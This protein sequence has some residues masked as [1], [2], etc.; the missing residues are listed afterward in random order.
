MDAIERLC[1]D[2]V[3][4]SRQVSPVSTLCGPRLHEPRRVPLHDRANP[5]APFIRAWLAFASALDGKAERAAIEL[6]EARRLSSD[7]RYSS[8]ARL[9]AANSWAPKACALLETT[10]FAGLR[11]VGVPEE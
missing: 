2:H 6:A 4:P 8:I 3:R 7:D 9:T 5:A 10:Y 1:R 11:K